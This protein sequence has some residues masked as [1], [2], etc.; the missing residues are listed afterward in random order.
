MTA[1]VPGFTAA[2]GTA[3]GVET[4][5]VSDFA[6]VD[7]AGATSG[8]IAGDVVV[9]AVPDGKGCEFEIALVF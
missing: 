5:G 9:V 2:P 1:G 3:G 8:V 4:T 6:G 7:A